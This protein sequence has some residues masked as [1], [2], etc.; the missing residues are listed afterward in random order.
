MRISF[1]K[2]LIELVQEMDV[3]EVEIRRWFTSIRIK[4]NSAGAPLERKGTGI[5]QKTVQQP[6]EAEKA[7]EKSTEI[8]VT[9]IKTP[10]VGT[11]YRAPASDAPPYVEIGDHVSVGKIVCIVEAM[12]IMNEIE[13][14]VSGTLTD[15]LVKNE[16]P[17]EYNQQ[18]FL[19]NPE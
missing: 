14:D 4:M 7:E 16:D 15:I 1:V 8:N 9:A 5:H 19:V 12:K 2:K 3:E 11:F 17:V 6:V 13:S 18:L 10:M